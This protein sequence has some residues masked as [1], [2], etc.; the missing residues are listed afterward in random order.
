MATEAEKERRK[1]YFEKLKVEDFDRYKR[2]K[3]RGKYKKKVPK[4]PYVPPVHDTVANKAKRR[5]KTGQNRS[6]RI[7]EFVKFIKGNFKCINCPESCPCCLDFHHLDPTLKD[8]D[9]SECLHNGSMKKLLDEVSK[10]VV[11]CSNCHRKIHSGL[12]VLNDVTTIDISVLNAL[13]DE[14]VEKHHPSYFKYLNMQES[15]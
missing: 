5:L 3:A 11:L 2:Y 1:R 14:F 8:R 13:R 10:C 12:I 6:N 15:I 4:P 9:V 7:R